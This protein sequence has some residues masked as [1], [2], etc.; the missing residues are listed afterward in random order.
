MRNKLLVIATIEL[1]VLAFTAGCIQQQHRLYPGSPRPPSEV[2]I[3][4]CGPGRGLLEAAF[5]ITEI[6]GRPGPSSG[7]YGLHCVIELEPGPHA[8]K[9]MFTRGTWFTGGAVSSDRP[10]PVQ[11]EAKGG[12]RYR[13]RAEMQRPTAAQRALAVTVGIPGSVSAH[14]SIV[15][16]D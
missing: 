13:L 10:I 14:V 11:F 2:A 7:H 4:E 6:D 9:V 1:A 12:K 5:W 15:E 16:G 3:L 8:V